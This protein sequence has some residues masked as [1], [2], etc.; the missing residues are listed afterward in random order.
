MKSRTGTNVSFGIEK[1]LNDSIC[2]AAAGEFDYKEKEQNH[3][4]STSGVV[5][6]IGKARQENQFFPA[7]NDR[8]LEQS[9]QQD[10]IRLK[11]TV[12]DEAREPIYANLEDIEAGNLDV[13]ALET[14]KA[15]GDEPRETVS[16]DVVSSYGVSDLGTTK[17]KVSYYKKF[18]MTFN[19]SI[20][21]LIWY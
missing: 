10:L 5:E 19:Y 16:N 12:V 17:D 18:I 13:I 14:E 15:G 21:N 6:E 2:P 4:S 3:R 1:T 8:S 20:L 11:N 9:W 7:V